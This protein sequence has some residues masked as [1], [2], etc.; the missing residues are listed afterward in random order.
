MTSDIDRGHHGGQY[1]YWDVHGRLKTV[2]VLCARRGRVLIFR[3][4]D[5]PE[6]PKILDRSFGSQT[7]PLR[8]ADVPLE[9]LLKPLVFSMYSAAVASHPW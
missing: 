4:N 6:Y 3:I 5:I 2:T 1:Q 8:A 9:T 7:D